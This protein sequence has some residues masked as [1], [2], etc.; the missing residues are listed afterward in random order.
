MG[1]DLEWHWRGK[2]LRAMT[3]DELIAVCVELIE[4]RRS[5]EMKQH[6]DQAEEMRRVFGLAL[7]GDIRK[8][9]WR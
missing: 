4:Q 1:A 3:K 2:P 6:A 7:G 8:G 5:R 9:Y